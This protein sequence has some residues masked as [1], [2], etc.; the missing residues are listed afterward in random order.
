MSYSVRQNTVDKHFTV[1]RQGNKISEIIVHHAAT[2][3]FDGIAN[4]FRGDRQASAHYAVGR[5][6]NVDKMVDEAN[7][8]WHCGNWGHNL[9]SIGIENVNSS[10]AP[11]WAVAP[12]TFNTLVE[13]CT[14]IVKRNPGI[15]KLE[16]GRN[17]FGHKDVSDS[18]TAC[19]VQL[20][21]RLRELADRVNAAVAGTPVP[22]PQTPGK[23]NEELADEVLAGKWGNNPGRRDALIGAGYNYAAIQAIVNARVGQAPSAPRK[24]NDVIA[25]EVLA[26][27]WGNNP[28]RKQRLEQ[29]GYNYEAI[30]AIVNQRVGGGNANAPVPARPSDEAIADQ[31]IAGAWGNGE[32]RKAKL[33]NAGYD[34]GTVQAIVNRKL[35]I[36]AGAPARKSDDQV[37]NEVLAG[38]WGNGQERKDRLASA[39]Y[40]YGTIQAIVNR[41]LG[42]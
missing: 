17:L 7:T 26:G 10:G 2:T 33:A 39:G 32:D 21:A 41:K 40:D 13:L 37:A 36:G 35:G 30:Q 28:T 38:N 16:V 14:D 42:L 4:T 29:A 27:A 8:A 3:Y 5:N 18:P 19:P 34:Y 31:V 15:G 22:S 12:E 6:N 24:S 1:G 20:E 9:R 23:S 11:E 25:D